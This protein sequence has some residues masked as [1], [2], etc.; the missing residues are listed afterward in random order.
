MR[1]QMLELVGCLDGRIDR[2][3]SDAERGYAA[4]QVLMGLLEAA[5]LG[6][7]VSF[8]VRR[9]EYPLDV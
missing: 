6:E 7:V 9:D 1:M 2:H 5:R 8:P 4:M 3:R